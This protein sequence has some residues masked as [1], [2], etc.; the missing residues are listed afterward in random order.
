MAKLGWS[1]R[2]SGKKNGSKDMTAASRANMAKTG[3]SLPDGSF[4][5]PTPDFARR[6]LSSMGRVPPEK[7]AAVKS[8]IKKKIRQN[9][10]KGGWAAVA[11]HPALNM[12]RREEIT[13]ELAMAVSASASVPA[14]S[15]SD[16]PRA[17][18]PAAS[19]GPAGR[20]A[21]KKLKKKGKPDPQALAMAKFVD[22]R[23]KAK[24]GK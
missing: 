8:L 4:P 16:G 20:A 9:G 5:V 6:A 7:R 12:T 21:F 2:K 17:T 15:A 24:A 3:N 1:L 22:R 14:V 19:L 11:K 10:G 18:G 13:L 23:V